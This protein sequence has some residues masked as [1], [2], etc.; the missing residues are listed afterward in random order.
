MGFDMLV[1]LAIT[2]R[3][4]LPNMLDLCRIVPCH[5]LLLCLLITIMTLFPHEVKL[6]AARIR[7]IV[8]AELGRMENRDWRP[9]S[10]NL[11]RIFVDQ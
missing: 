9:S 10:C 5:D 4:R 1:P 7:E 11:L 3:N 8:N 6:F 2:R